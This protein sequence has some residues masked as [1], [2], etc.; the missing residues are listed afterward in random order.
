MTFKVVGPPIYTG[1]LKLIIYY[2]KKRDEVHKEL[3]ISFTENIYEKKE[4]LYIC[5]GPPWRVEPD[6]FVKP[7]SMVV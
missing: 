7:V 1:T 2:L 3:P 4:V 6:D 5:K